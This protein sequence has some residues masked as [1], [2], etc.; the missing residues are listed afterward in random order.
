MFEMGVLCN[1]A[2]GNVLRIVPP[3]V[4]TRDEMERATDILAEALLA[5]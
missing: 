4:I 2:G 1:A 3:L 5:R